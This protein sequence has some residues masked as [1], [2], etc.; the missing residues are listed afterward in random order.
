MH[1]CTEQAYKNAHN[2]EYSCIKISSLEKNIVPH[3]KE[4]RF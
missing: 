2:T 3:L 1:P 4:I